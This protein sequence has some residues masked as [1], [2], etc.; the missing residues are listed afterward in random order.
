VRDLLLKRKQKVTDIDFVCIGSGIK[1]A[2]QLSKKLGKEATFKVFK[3]FGTAMINFNNENYEFVGARKESYRTNSR[4]PIVENGTL[5]DDQNRRDFTI[6]AMAIELNNDN[7]GELSDPFNGVKDLKEKIIR[8]PLDPNITY[9]DDPLRMMR[10]V[11]F[12]SQLN[13]KI[14]ENSF[15]SIC[16]NADR[17]SII[18]QERITDEL[19]RIILSC[20]IID[21]LSAFLQID[22]NEFSSILKLS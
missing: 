12:A 18:S 13:F 20:D 7:Y 9:S 19:N 1:F 8:T 14:E 22:L 3:N 4:K 2:E 17:L 5:E 11:R 6:N 10:A 16:K 15:K 21:N